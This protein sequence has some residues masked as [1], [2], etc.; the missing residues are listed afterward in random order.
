MVSEI[1]MSLY[2]VELGNIDETPFDFEL[3][4]RIQVQAKMNRAIQEN[5]K[6]IKVD[7]KGLLEIQFDPKVRVANFFES[8]IKAWRILSPTSITVT[9]ENLEDAHVAQLTQFLSGRNLI[10][11]LN[12]RRN[13][14]GDKG[15]IDIANYVKKA[16]RTLISLE[17][18]RNEIND[19]GGEAILRS[20][21]AN[22]RMEQC[23]VGYGNPMKQKI[24][25]Q[26]DRE[27]K[28]NLQI[29][30]DVVPIYKE[31]GNSL[32]FYEGSDRGPDFVRCAL[33]S[34]ELFKILHLSLPDNMIG[35]KEMMDIAYVLQKNTPLTILD[36]SNNVIDP[37]AA[38]I[39][40]NALGT[41]SNLRQLDLRNNKLGNCGVAQ[42]MEVFIKQSLQK[43]YRNVEK[44]RY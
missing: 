21:Q 5:L 12:L 33:K 25:R 1:N 24:A 42:I 34:C 41:N 6:P 17:L 38:Q 8:A 43:H 39:L 32:K 28:A 40:S 22:M 44:Q 4:K 15:A 3:V 16:D 20:M 23:K 37:K 31:N 29:R 30:K 13:K 18:E 26:I 14:I 35:E 9:N 2:N 27:I 36:L 19:E 7:K 11:Q 10:K